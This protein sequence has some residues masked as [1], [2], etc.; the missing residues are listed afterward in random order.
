MTDVIGVPA[1][2]G[3]ENRGQQRSCGKRSR[4]GFCKSEGSAVKRRALG[5]LSNQVDYLAER[6]TLK[7]K[8]VSLLFVFSHLFRT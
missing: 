1:A 5:V 6:Q 2:G 3:Q 4:H 7:N 8:T